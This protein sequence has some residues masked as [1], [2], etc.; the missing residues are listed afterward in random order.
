MSEEEQKIIGPAR[1]QELEAARDLIMAASN[2]E[3]RALFANVIDNLQSLK[4][5]LGK[6]ENRFN[7]YRDI[8]VDAHTIFTMFIGQFLGYPTNWIANAITKHIRRAGRPI[9]YDDLTRKVNCFFISS[10]VQR[11]AS[12]TQAIK[13]L[14]RLRGDRAMTRGHHI[15]LSR[16]YRDYEKISVNPDLFDDH[17]EYGEIIG[18]FFT[19][20]LSHLESDE[21]ASL[22]AVKAFKMFIGELIDLMKNMHPIIAERDE[23]Y[24]KIYGDLP[25]IL[26]QHHENPLDYFYAVPLKTQEH[27]NSRKEALMQYTESMFYYSLKTKNRRN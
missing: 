18:E 15:E 13:L 1:L 6:P 19:F 21:K 22:K 23:E 7:S 27:I 10:L 9:K 4:K 20:T 12:E 26:K 14:M 5:E 11:G 24:P 8:T 25:D 16:T 3:K 17:F 2:T